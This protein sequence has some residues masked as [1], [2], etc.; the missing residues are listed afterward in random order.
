MTNI[1]ILTIQQIEHAIDTNQELVQLTTSDYAKVYFLLKDDYLKNR[2][3]HQSTMDF[4][5]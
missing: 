5:S 4:H 2:K 1:N 3:R